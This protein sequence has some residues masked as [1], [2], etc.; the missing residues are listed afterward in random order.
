MAITRVGQM[1]PL[2]VT[3]ELLSA[4]PIDNLKIDD[5]TAVFRRGLQE[6]E[7]FFKSQP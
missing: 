5:L 7:R 6:V 1:T 2:E 3:G 4:G